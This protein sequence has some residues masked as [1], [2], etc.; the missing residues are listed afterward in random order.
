MLQ[1]F[2]VTSH[3]PAL[4]SSLMCLQ[5]LTAHRQLQRAYILP[6]RALSVQC[7]R[8]P[9]TL[10]QLS[11]LGIQARHRASSLRCERHGQRRCS[12][13]AR[14]HVAFL[15]ALPELSIPLSGV[16]MSRTRPPDET[17][18][19]LRTRERMCPEY[20]PAQSLHRASCYMRAERLVV[21]ARRTTRGRPVG[22]PPTPALSAA[23]RSR[24]VIGGWYGQS[25]RVSVNTVRRCCNHLFDGLRVGCR[26]G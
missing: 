17:C 19:A 12:R 9:A 24:A 6:G 3:A 10:R 18:P 26:T 2:H 7:D 14:L 8:S 21:R 4:L 23:L 22:R 25:P 11:Q 5:E 15:V 16:S 13:N 1:V 20:I